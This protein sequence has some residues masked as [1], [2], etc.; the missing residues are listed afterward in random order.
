MTVG[1]AKG[2][3][4]RTMRPGTPNRDAPGLSRS[5]RSTARLD[6]GAVAKHDAHGPPKTESI[7]PGE[8]AE[9]DVKDG[10]AVGRGLRVVRQILSGP[11]RRVVHCP[12]GC[13]N[14]LGHDQVSAGQDLASDEADLPGGVHE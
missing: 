14:G 10:L 9:G 1:P 3:R 5:D 2:H 11:V 7:G 4:I 8:T 13:A 12:D 6:A